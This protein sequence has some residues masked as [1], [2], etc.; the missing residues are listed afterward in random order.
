MYVILQRIDDGSEQAI[1]EGLDADRALMEAT[2]NELVNDANKRK[3]NVKY[4]LEYFENY[5]IDHLQLKGTGGW[6]NQGEE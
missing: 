4:R 1:I 5:N 6:V 3:V 2:Y